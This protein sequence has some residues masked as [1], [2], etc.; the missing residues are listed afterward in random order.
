[1]NFMIPFS[2][3]LLERHTITCFWQSKHYNY[4]PWR[5]LSSALWVSNRYL[6]TKC[7]VV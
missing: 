5:F 1:M 6:W 3:L 7:Y 4:L 2:L